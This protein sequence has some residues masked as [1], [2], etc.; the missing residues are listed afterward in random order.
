MFPCVRKHPG[1]TL[2]SD[3]PADVSAC[4]TAPV[5]TLPSIGR[6]AEMATVHALLHSAGED[7]G[8]FVFLSGE[9]GVGK[10]RLLEQI[11]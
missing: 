2:P 6:E 9:R 3:R 10:T 8:S 11:A 1:S 7:S 5:G 4:G